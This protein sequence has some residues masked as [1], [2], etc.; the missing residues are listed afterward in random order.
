MYADFIG[1]WNKCRNS[2]LENEFQK[3]WNNLLTNFPI[4]KAYLERAL[5]TNVISWALCYTYRSFNAGIQSTQRVEGY[6]ALIK[7][8]VSKS[9]TLFELDIQIQLQ[10]DKEEQ[11]ERQ[12]EQIVQNPT[13]GLPNII[14]RYFKKIDIIVKKYLTPR[15]LKIQH[16]QM[17]ESLLYHIK[18][19]ENW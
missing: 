19:I 8:S 4:A 17:N 2:F 11:F 16:Q 18:K 10:L 9:T 7:K 3:Q 12:E 14:N 1:A 15:I 13:V 5:G 6:N